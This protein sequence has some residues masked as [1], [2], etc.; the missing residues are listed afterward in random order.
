M[1]KNGSMEAK[2]EELEGRIV[3]LEAEISLFLKPLLIE[4]YNKLS[5][6]GQ[7]DFATPPA[8]FVWL[9][10]NFRYEK[11]EARKVFLAGLYEQLKQKIPIGPFD[12]PEL[13]I[14]PEPDLSNIFDR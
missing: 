12:M 6:P 13:R 14:E 4:T 2:I 3:G 7:S 11:D 10:E 1:S 9:K 8:I 5:E